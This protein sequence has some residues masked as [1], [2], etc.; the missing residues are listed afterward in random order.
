MLRVNLGIKIWRRD[1]AQHTTCEKKKK[2]KRYVP[3]RDV[4]WREHLW[5]EGCDASTGAAKKAKQKQKKHVPLSTTDR[6]WLKALRSR[7]NPTD[8]GHFV[9]V[10]FGQVL[11][12][13]F[14]GTTK[15][16]AKA[17]TEQ[18]HKR[19]KSTNKRSTFHLNGQVLVEGTSFQ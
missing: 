12:E 4:T 19:S 11:V 1:E 3:L 14:I 18:K 17:K 8:A 13:R 16:K 5:C 6:S 10:P 15:P 7:E 2:K 9:N